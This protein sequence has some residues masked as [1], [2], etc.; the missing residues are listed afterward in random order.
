MFLKR[1]STSLGSTCGEQQRLKASV[2]RPPLRPRGEKTKRRSRALP[3]VGLFSEFMK[4]LLVSQ[5][6]FRP[7]SDRLVRLFLRGVEHCL[8]ARDELRPHHRHCHATRSLNEALRNPQTIAGGGCQQQPRRGKLAPLSQKEFWS[9]ATPSSAYNFSRRVG[10]QKRRKRSSH[11]LAVSQTETLDQVLHH[12]RKGLAVRERPSPQRTDLHLRLQSQPPIT[13]IITT[14]ITTVITTKS[15][16]IECAL[17]KRNAG[18][19]R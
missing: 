5:K 4:L 2:W 13:T 10:R 6:K 11:G 14:V 18:R 15:K 7:C 3:H 12:Q 19:R 8:Y 1:I 9:R 17:S 16:V